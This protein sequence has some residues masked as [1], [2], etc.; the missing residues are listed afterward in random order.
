MDWWNVLG[1]E[2]LDAG[3]P[4]LRQLA[5]Q[6]LIDEGIIR[7]PSQTI[8]PVQVQ[9]FAALPVGTLERDVGGNDQTPLFVAVAVIVIVLL[10]RR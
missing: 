5:A 1:N 10:I 7:R 8:F 3:Q 9:N 2:V 4:L 6:K